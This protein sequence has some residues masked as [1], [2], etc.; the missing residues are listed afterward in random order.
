MDASS[1]PIGVFIRQI[2]SRSLLFRLPL[3]LYK[4]TQTMYI[5]PNPSENSYTAYDQKEEDFVVD[6]GSGDAESPCPTPPLQIQIPLRR[7][8]PCR[9][10]RA[11]QSQKRKSNLRERNSEEER[12]CGICFQPAV[13]PVHTLCCA[14]P[15]CAEHIAAWLT[16]PA[17]DGRC[18][19]CRAL[20]SLSL[21]ASLLL[22]IGDNPRALPPSRCATPSPTSAS[23]SDYTVS[24]SPSSYGSTSSESDYTQDESEDATDY[25]L[26]ALLHARALQTR[27]HVPHPFSSVLGARA[28]LS[29][30]V[31]L[32][33]WVLVVGLLA[34]RGGWGS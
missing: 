33:G 1:A 5:N 13:S 6:L 19:A 4:R 21:S 3:R 29:R 20:V 32:A 31:R 9:P 23:D 26:P 7:P 27:R 25:S 10:Y 11:A 22:S 17:S 15:F 16:G 12:E 8:I 2:K 28:A 18:P 14:H 34:A 30:I 24:P